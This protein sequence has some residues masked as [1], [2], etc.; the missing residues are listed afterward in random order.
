M[1]LLIA[2]FTG[3]LLAACLASPSGA[4]G[5]TVMRFKTDGYAFANFGGCPDVDPLPPGTVCRETQLAVFREGVA[6]DGGSGIAPP[7]TPWVVNTFTYTVT[8]DANGEGTLSD[9]VFGFRLLDPNAVTYDREHLAFASL[10][11]QIPL[12]DGTSADV[13]FHWQATSDR[14]VSGNDGSALGDFG[15]V[16]KFVDK[17]STVVNQ[18]HQKSRVAAMNGTW[19]GSPVHSYTSFDSAFISFNHFVFIDASHGGCQP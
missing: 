16:R 5:T 9:D 19:N 17:C 11:T 1:R 8:I 2:L 14:S 7:K 12:T 15:L 4:G 18:G 13:D 6:I 3:A 10:H